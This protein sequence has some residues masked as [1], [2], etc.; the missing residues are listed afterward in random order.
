VRGETYR[1]AHQGTKAAAEFQKILDHRGIVLNEPIGALAHLQIGRA[2]AM[3]GDT[4][5]AKAA[6]QDFLTLWKDADLDIPIFIA[7]KA[8][9]AKLK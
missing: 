1:A 5:R 8:E 4:A 6:Y 7:A 9:Y 2:Y 3:Q